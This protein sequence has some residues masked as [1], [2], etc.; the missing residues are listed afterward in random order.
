MFAF[1]LARRYFNYILRVLSDNRYEKQN[2]EDKNCVNINKPFNLHENRWLL[3]VFVR[4]H[5]Q[6]VII[7]D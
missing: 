2:K 4:G 7:D 5:M 1:L 3:K 6:V